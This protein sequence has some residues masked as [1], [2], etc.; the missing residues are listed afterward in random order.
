MGVERE[1]AVAELAKPSL[2]KPKLCLPK[3]P[4]PNWSTTA[5]SSG[6]VSS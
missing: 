2:T 1:Q 5:P 4:P 3:R 6:P